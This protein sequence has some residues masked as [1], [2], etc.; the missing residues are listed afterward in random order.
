MFKKVI[1]TNDVGAKTPAMYGLGYVDIKERQ[2]VYFL[3]PIN[4]FVRLWKSAA[5]RWNNY[6]NRLSWV[7]K[8]VIYSLQLPVTEDF[9]RIYF[10]VQEIRLAKA[11]AVNLA[12]ENLMNEFNIK[13]DEIQMV[14]TQGSLDEYYYFKDIVLLAVLWEF[15]NKNH[16]MSFKIQQYLSRRS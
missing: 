6:R 11:K 2:I 5:V 13:I 15:D 9:K 8:Q 16:N 4:I 7:D 10:K 1:K 12:L 14:V 3:Y